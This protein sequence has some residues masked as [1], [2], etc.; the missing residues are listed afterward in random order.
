MKKIKNFFKDV[1]KEISKVKWPT[2][3]DMFKYSLTV[4]LFIGLSG[5]ILS[6]PIGIAVTSSVSISGLS[7]AGIVGVILNQVMNLTYRTKK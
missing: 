4:I 7:L 3:K 5:N 1:K 2:K 6:S